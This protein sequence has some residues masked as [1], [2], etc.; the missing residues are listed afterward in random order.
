MDIL[1]YINTLDKRV[2]RLEESNISLHDRMGK[3]E[4]KASSAWKHINE[5]HDRMNRIENKVEGLEKDIKEVKIVQD[6]SA[7]TLKGLLVCS[8][9]LCVICASFFLYIWRNDAELAKM[10]LSFGAQVG[11][12]LA[13]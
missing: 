7:K 9:V 12:G 2:G 11:T 13:V 5:V 10:V 3:V 8:A 1:D 4:D 6:K